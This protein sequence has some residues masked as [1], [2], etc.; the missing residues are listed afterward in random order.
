MVFYNA[1]GSMSGIFGNK[2]VEWSE[3]EFDVIK[4][5]P[6]TKTLIYYNRRFVNEVAEDPTEVED[7]TYFDDDFIILSNLV[8]MERMIS[9]KEIVSISMAILKKVLSEKRIR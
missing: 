8:F 2:L 1:N 3:E 5:Q 9:S 6:Q 4:E 7:I